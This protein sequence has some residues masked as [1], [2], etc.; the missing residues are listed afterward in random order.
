M[1]FLSVPLDQKVNKKLE[2][3]LIELLKTTKSAAVSKLFEFEEY[4]ISSSRI[5]EGEG[6]SL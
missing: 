5:K 2:E 1:K 3:S 4:K 6:G